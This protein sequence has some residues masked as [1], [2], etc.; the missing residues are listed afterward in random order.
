MVRRLTPNTDAN[1]FTPLPW[2][3]NSLDTVSS[4]NLFSHRRRNQQIR[5]RYPDSGSTPAANPALY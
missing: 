2:V 1:S 5:T 4:L 3:V